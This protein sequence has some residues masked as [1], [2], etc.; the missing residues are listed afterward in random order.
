MDPSQSTS[1]I[2]AGFARSSQWLNPGDPAKSCSK[3]KL[4]QKK[5]LVS[6]RWTSAGVVHYSFLKSGQTITADIYCHQLQITK[7]ELAAKQP[8]LVYLSRPLL[9]HDNARPQTVTIGM[10]ATCTIIYSPDLA[11][12]DYHFFWNLDNFLQ[13]KKFNSDAADQT[14]FKEFIVSRPKVFLVKVSMNYLCDGKSA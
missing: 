7:E 13:R 3:R 10:S 5:L 9:L 11:L 1:E 4:T 6:V 2:A 14:A 12:T 8:R